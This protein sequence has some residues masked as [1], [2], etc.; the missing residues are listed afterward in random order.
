LVSGS[1]SCTRSLASLAR[2]C[3]A[4]AVSKAGRGP[5]GAGDAHLADVVLGR[6][7]LLRPL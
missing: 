5:G 6:L 7:V 1:S 2:S 3:E 4:Q